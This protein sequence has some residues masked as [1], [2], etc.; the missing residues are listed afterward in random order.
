MHGRIICKT[1]YFSVVVCF[2]ELGSSVSI[3]SGYRL[4][5]LGSIPDTDKGFFF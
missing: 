5:D 1:E 3:V 4:D 2:E